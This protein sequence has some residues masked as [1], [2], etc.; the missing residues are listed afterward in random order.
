MSVYPTVCT[1][2]PNPVLDARGTVAV[3]ADMASACV[4]LTI[5]GKTVISSSKCVKSYKKGRGQVI[6]G[7]NSRETQTRT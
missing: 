6:R 3:E 5:P 2:E 7:R 4:E 1:S